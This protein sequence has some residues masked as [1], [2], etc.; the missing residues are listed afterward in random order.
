MIGVGVTLGA[1]GIVAATLWA[2]VPT[3]SV[4]LRPSDVVV[5]ALGEKV[6]AA[7]CASCHGVNLE[8]EPNWRERGPDGRLPAP[9]HDETGH[10][11]HHPDQMLFQLTKYGPP[12]EMGNGEPYFSNMPAYE[13]VLSDEEIVAVLS[14]IKSR[15]P[16][17]VRQRHDEL[18]AQMAAQ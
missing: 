8:G 5:V 7:Q 11:F 6:Y 16:E 17:A 18:N 1:G 12:K 14:Y 4:A 10:T 3:G 15:W 13:T 9:P 2:T